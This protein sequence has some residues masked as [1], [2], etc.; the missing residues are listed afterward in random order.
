MAALPPVVVSLII[1]GAAMG[2]QYLLTPKI[3]NNPT[4][5][6]KID[7]LRVTGSEFGTFIP[8]FW[9]QVR[10]GGNV[11][12]A[13]GIDHQ[14][15][16]RP[17]E[18]GKGSPSG[19]A[20]RVHVYRTDLWWAIGRSKVDKWLKLW[21]DQN[22]LVNLAGDY[23]GEFEAEDNSVFTKSGT[24]LSVYD[25]T[26]SGDY[27]VRYTGSA[28]T[29]FALNCSSIT[30]PTKSASATEDP[31]D[32]TV[33]KTLV[34]YYYKCST[35]TTTTISYNVDDGY[36]GV[37]SATRSITIPASTE[38]TVH[39]ELVD[40]F[41][42]SITTPV[43]VGSTFELDKMNISYAWMPDTKAQSSFDTLTGLT[44]P[45]YAYP[46]ASTNPSAFYNYKPTPDANGT[47]TASSIYAPNMAFYNGSATQQVYTPLVTWL[48][49]KYG[50][51]V[52]TTYAPAFRGLSGIA[53]DDFELQDGR[54]PNFTVEVKNNDQSVNEI[55][56]E[57]A[58]DVGIDASLLELSATNAL[59][60]FGYVEHTKASRKQ[61][62][63]NL[64]KYWGFNYA[65]IDGKITTILD[66]FTSDGTISSNSLRAVTEGTDTPVYDAV[67]SLA[68]HGEVA[69]E[70]QFTFM[71]PAIEYHNDVARSS[72]FAGVSSSDYVGLNFPIV[73]TADE[74]QQQA[75]KFL[76]KLHSEYQ[77]V[78]FTCL[79][80]VMKY[81][82]GDNITV[83]INGANY[84]VRIDKK[85]VGL[86]IGNITI[87]GTI[88]EEYEAA[89]ITT[90][91]KAT[92]VSPLRFQQF[93]SPAV[94]RNAKVVAFNSLPVKDTDRG[95]LG[96][97]VAVTPVGIGA[98]ETVSLYQ[99]YGTDNFVLKEIFEIPSSVGFANST[100]GN[101]ATPSTE[102][103]TN[104]LDIYFYNDVELES[105]DPSTGFAQLA[106]YPNLNLLR[107]GNEW[108][109]FKTATAGTLPANTPYRSRW[110]VSNLARGRFSTTSAIGSHTAS[111]DVVLVTQNLRYVALSDADVSQTVR[112]KAVSAGM[113]VADASITS[114]VFTP[115]SKYTVTNRTADR[116]FDADCTTIN[117][118]SD[119]IGT[120][121]DDLKI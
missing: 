58:A 83:P 94:P 95:R 103:T 114:L 56:T 117:E 50:V 120:I 38:W 55:L 113:D 85:T 71:N 8:R 12:W 4:D 79:P 112:F 18:G 14:I 15:Y 17:S 11:I 73:A 32:T 106:R 33:P 93:S 16:D 6:G 60:V 109:Q 59:T 76:L 40:G 10:L 97:Y 91:I 28:T 92:D 47:S 102:D 44:D 67:I 119:V 27:Y 1:T 74:A 45:N 99:E 52:G 88:L 25:V 66:S 7:D 35:A 5:V 23:S 31:G 53:F 81:A 100:L 77:T 105:L 26:V 87:N 22:V 80:E 107:V 49:A 111:E 115:Q 75:E 69:K 51:G 63:D 41:V 37:T 82:I 36:G 96:V 2:A 72:L 90:A 46:S 43:P 39:T 78:E 121:I 3:K 54:I 65:E 34:F 86:P 42:I 19:P 13:G 70:V 68:P 21:G 48:D 20:E 98:S 57:L 89:D 104:T 62:Y 64:S 116:T 61:H 110:T 29:Q 24:Y 101:W 108:V 84:L 118:L 9:G 30:L